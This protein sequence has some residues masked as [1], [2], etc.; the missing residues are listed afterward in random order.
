MHIRGYHGKWTLLQ[1]IR[2]KPDAPIRLG[3][4]AHVEDDAI[5]TLELAVRRERRGEAIFDPP[6]PSLPIH[7]PV[8]ASHAAPPVGEASQG[9]YM[10]IILR[11]IEKPD[12]LL[13]RLRNALPHGLAAYDAR[14]VPLK[15]SSLMSA[16][17]GFAYTLKTPGDASQIAARVEALLI[18]DAL[19]VERKGKSKRGRQPKVVS[20]DLRP[21]LTELALREADG[22]NVVIDF[23]TMAV[24]G[25]TAKPKEMIALL[26]LDPVATRVTKRD[27]YLS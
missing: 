13:T 8:H 1:N 23:T 9:D 19:P 24:N 27:T 26:E 12:R 11:R 4:I 25:K 14:E 6:Y 2:E 22:P 3:T 17:T 5:H 21:T 7:D 10:D 18:A 20:V 16:V 15:A